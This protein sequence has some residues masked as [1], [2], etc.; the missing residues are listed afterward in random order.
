MEEAQPKT[1]LLYSPRQIE[2]ATLLA[3]PPQYI[4]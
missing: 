4:C 2:I 3:S 1:G